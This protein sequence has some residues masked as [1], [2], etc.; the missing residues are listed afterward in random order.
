MA[1]DT[2]IQKSPST[3]MNNLLSSSAVQDMIKS[4]L[5]ENADLFCTSIIELYGSD[6]T[7]QKCD[8]GEVIKECM[9]AATLKLPLNK[10]LGFAWVIAR[11][12]SKLGRF[13][14]QFQPGWKGIVQLAQRTAQYQFIN[15]G[16]VF[17][18][19]LR[20]ISK[21]T[22][23][24]DIEGEAVSENVTG[25]FAYIQLNNGFKKA[26]Y[27]T[28]DKTEKHAL[29]YNP[30]SKKAGKLTGIWAEYFDERAMATVL[31][32]LITKYGI[33]SIEMLGALKNDEE[34]PAE[35]AE[36]EI[37]GNANSEIIGF[38]AE[39]VNTHTGEVKGEVASEEPSTAAE[40]PSF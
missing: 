3:V 35:A 19:E 14:P 34:S 37:A 40:G 32:M 28:K 9:K 12:N 26:L 30:E 21:L 15:C 27:W 5:K 11:W 22:G 38:T 1:N 25:Y 23:E 4:S 7:L 33:M 16:P 17:E 39:V 24:L 13:V 29:R 31:K 6:T 10:S 2:Q 8:P 20:K 36:R 18:G